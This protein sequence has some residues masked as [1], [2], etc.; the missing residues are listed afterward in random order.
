MPIHC[1]IELPRLSEAE[2]RSIDYVVMGHAF[3]THNELGRL[4]DESV[5]QRELLRRLR[6]SEF[7][8]STE[9]PITLSFRGFSIG[10]AL[11]LVF[12]RKAI[13]ELK[14][15]SEL[16]TSHEGQL[17]E[18][19]YLT[20]ST[21]GKL[22]NFRN[23]SVESRF[24]NTTFDTLERQMFRFDELGYTGDEFLSTLVRELVE[25]WGTGLNASLYRRAILSCTGGVAESEQLLPMVAEGSSL[26]INDFTCCRPTQH[27]GLRRIRILRLQTKASL[28]N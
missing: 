17:L 3:D 26:A 4:C 19:L 20:N 9:V 7:E 24:V 1:E 22:V 12:A 10:R 8:V 16:L 21:R 28:K 13:Y 6:I 25:E 15:V 14:A 23:M 18:Y 11:D 5:Y 27:S 2:M